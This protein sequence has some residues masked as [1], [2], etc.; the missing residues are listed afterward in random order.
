MNG[1]LTTVVG[2]AAVVCLLIGNSALAQST[3]TVYQISL[4]GSLV[5]PKEV[6]S[7]HTAV[8]TDTFTTGRLIN[9]ARGR[10]PE[11]TVPDNEK[12]ALVLFF[13][14][15]G[16][17]P[18]GGITV[19]D[20]AGQSN[21]A[22]VVEMQSLYGILDSVTGKGRMNMVGELQATGLLSG[23][24]LA[25]S[26]T[27]KATNPTTAPH[28]TMMTGSTVEGEIAGNDGSKDFDVMITNGKLK[29]VGTLGTITITPE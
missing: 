24:W 17:N 16:S 8:A 1:K 11:V 2:V 18:T 10:S 22:L 5:K 25:I 23:G 15:E 19:Y 14:S 6:N 7:N 12:L 4:K 27:A 20:T 29:L 21:L 13:D 3:G 26:G 9:L 28:F